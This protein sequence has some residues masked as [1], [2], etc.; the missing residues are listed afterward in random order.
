MLLKADAGPTSQR[1]TRHAMTYAGASEEPDAS[2]AAEAHT[3]HGA[4]PGA[5]A[6]ASSSSSIYPWLPWAWNVCMNSTFLQN[7]STAI[8]SCVPPVQEER[9]APVKKR[10]R[11][12]TS[13]ACTTCRES[14]VRCDEARPCSRCVSRNCSD[15][16]VDWRK[17]SKVAKTYPAGAISPLELALMHPLRPESDSS[18]SDSERLNEPEHTMPD[19]PALVKVTEQASCGTAGVVRD[20]SFEATLFDEEDDVFNNVLLQDISIPSDIFSASSCDVG[21]ASNR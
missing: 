3:S 7:Y 1:D 12:N 9:R 5:C 17:P 4:V 8:M 18:E 6:I 19:L 20:T 16:C 10:A 11:S 13:E 21:S 15:T 14:K 2:D